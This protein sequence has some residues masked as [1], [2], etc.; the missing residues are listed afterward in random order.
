MRRST[1]HPRL[2]RTATG[3]R[4]MASTPSMM[5]PCDALVSNVLVRFSGTVALTRV[6]VGRLM[7]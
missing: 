7:G 6:I 5:P 1:L 3:G 4:K 2:R